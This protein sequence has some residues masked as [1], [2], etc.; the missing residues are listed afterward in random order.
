MIAK[1]FIGLSL[2]KLQ[3]VSSFT[4]R[5]VPRNRIQFHHC[6]SQLPYSMRSFQTVR[7]QSDREQEFD[8][9]LPFESHAHGSAIIKIPQK[10]EKVIKDD[11]CLDPF[12]KTDFRRR[13][14]ATILACQNLKKSALWFQVPMNR[15]R[16]IE[17]M[18]D[19]GFQY[20]HAEG[21]IANLYLWLNDKIECK[22]PSFGT[23]QV[24]RSKQ[25]LDV[26]KKPKCILF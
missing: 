26:H 17:D 16:L 20:H 1:S 13:L 2:V 4:A 3:K 21:N 9:V 18:S 19:S 11:N 10:L 15:S 14:E 25:K 6:T 23:H 5:L 7:N 12:R 8:E 24:V 22:I